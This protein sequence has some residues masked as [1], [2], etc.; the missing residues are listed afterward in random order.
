MRGSH[1][2]NAERTRARWRN[3]AWRAA[4]ALGLALALACGADRDTGT[5]LAPTPTPAPDP[6]PS[7]LPIAT[8]EVEDFGALRIALF[9]H[10]APKTVANFIELAESGFYEGTTF[11]RVVPE[12]MIQGG[13]PNS[14][15]RD[16][17]N[18]GLGGPERG[19]ADEFNDTRFGRGVVGMAHSG[20]PGSAGSQF[21]IMVAERP[22]LDGHYTAFGRVLTG[23][24]VADRIAEVERDL[25]ARWGPR[26]RPIEDVMIA[27][28]SIERPAASAR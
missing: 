6:P 15:D 8:L 11:H 28:V 20:R 5:D 18:D 26:D 1:G 7:E 24:E 21:F 2:R 19:V 10:K 9:P 27:K 3:G 13:D 22:E 16:P 23:L 17:R 25:Y 14:K 4:A 12:F